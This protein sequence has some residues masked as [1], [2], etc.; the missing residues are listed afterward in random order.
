M[1]NDTSRSAPQLV[2]LRLFNFR[3]YSQYTLQGASSGITFLQG[4]NGTGKTSLLEAMSLLGAGRG[5]RNAQAADIT[6]QQSADQ[7]WRVEAQLHHNTQ[8]INVATYWHG[9]GARQVLV[10]TTP[11]TQQKLAQLW[12]LLW[13]CPEQDRLFA[14]GKEPRRSFF[15]RLLSGLYPTYARALAQYTK[16]LTE[17]MHVLQHGAADARWLSILEQRAATAAAHIITHRQDLC[18]QITTLWPQIIKS[19]APLQ[20]LQPL[21]LQPQGDAEDL[22]LGAS[23]FAIEQTFMHEWHAARA[24]DAAAKMTFFG[25]H[26]TG[27]AADIGQRAAHLLSSGEQKL[28]T[29]ALFVAT[30]LCAPQSPL[31]LIDD[32]TAYL[33]VNRANAALQMVQTF[34]P[35][36]VVSACV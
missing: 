5:L 21:L 18:A 26:R 2:W 29:V 3:C 23:G 12:P 10:N 6:R 4:A 30:C 22:C 19:A 31:V 34:L 16:D 32:L 20:V 36:A 1:L 28:L 33:D 24:R 27:Y 7:G 15:D 35:H 9:K 25:T 17:R 8:L 11:T 14:G 13:L